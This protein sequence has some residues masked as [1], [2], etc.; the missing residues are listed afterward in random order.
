MTAIQINGTKLPNEK[1]TLRTANLRFKEL[2]SEN[3]NSH[4]IINCNGMYMEYYRNSLSL[5]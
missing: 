4:I 3:P 5:N 2:V 1:H